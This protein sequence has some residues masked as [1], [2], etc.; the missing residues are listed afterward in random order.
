[1]MRLS[2]ASQTPDVQ[3]HK[4]ILLSVAF[5]F[6]E[7]GVR[8]D[9]ASMTEDSVLIEAEDYVK[10]VEIIEKCGLRILP[11]SD[12]EWTQVSKSI[13]IPYLRSM[14]KGQDFTSDEVIQACRLDWHMCSYGMQTLLAV[15]NGKVLNGRRLV[16]QDNLDLA[17]WR[18]E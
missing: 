14:P 10:A 13:V 5:L 4:D 6:R 7:E 8:Y 17:I 3:V 15:N 12:Y 11:K 18:W 2:I 16:R 1:M 9:Q